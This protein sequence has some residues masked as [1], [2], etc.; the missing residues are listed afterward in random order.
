MKTRILIILGLVFMPTLIFSQSFNSPVEYMD[1][2]SKEYKEITEESWKYT[3]AVAHGKSA[4]KVEKKRKEVLKTI[5]NARKT[6]AKVEGYNGESVLKD[7]VIS[8]LTFHYNVINYDYAKI[9]DMEAISEQSFDAMEAYMMAQDIASKKLNH[10]SDL[11]ILQQNE[12]ARNHNITINTD[13]SETTKKLKAANE[14]FDYYSEVYLIF[15]KSYKQE[16]YLLDAISRGDVNAIEQNKNAL[17]STSTEGLEK[18][19]DISH[20]KGNATIKMNCKKLLDFYKKEAENEIN[21]IT[22]FY[23]INENFTKVKTAFEAKKKSKRTQKD[24][25]AFNKAVKDVNEASNNYNTQ[26]TALFN[27]RSKL[28]EKWNNAVSKFLDQQ[29]SK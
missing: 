23:L 28:L 19:K 6:I 7:S 25:D 29:V 10:A 21:I 27:T 1:Y 15:F 4:R 11:L 2:M 24:F 12:Y 8:Y 5:D 22:E 20:F 16:A 17:I 18:I 9:V 3:S 14:V 13:E 26:N